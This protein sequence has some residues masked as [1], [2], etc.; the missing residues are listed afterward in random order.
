M[1]SLPYNYIYVC[2]MLARVYECLGVLSGRGLLLV[3]SFIL[4]E[5]SDLVG[6]ACVLNGI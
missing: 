3:G 1:H 2:C 6:C 4:F 5:E